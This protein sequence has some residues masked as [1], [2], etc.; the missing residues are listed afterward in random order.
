MITVERILFALASALC[1]GLVFAET[2]SVI[3]GSVVFVVAL[4]GCIGIFNYLET[5]N[6][7]RER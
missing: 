5:G 1:G 7:R 6:F 3:A 4:G 2:S